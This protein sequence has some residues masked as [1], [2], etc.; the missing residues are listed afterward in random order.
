MKASNKGRPEL[1]G[2]RSGKP[3]VSV[4]QIN[5]S[6]RKPLDKCPTGIPGLDEITRG[7]LPRGWPTLVSGAAGWRQRELQQESTSLRTQAE[8]IAARIANVESELS[9]LQR[10]EGDRNDT[11]SKQREQI[12]AARKAD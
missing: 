3:E 10:Q 9:I 1:D 4:E 5:E 6:R 12:S 8:G 2:T 11:A 7:G